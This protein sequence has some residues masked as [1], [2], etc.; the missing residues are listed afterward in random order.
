MK[1]IG[2]LTFEKF[3]KRDK[4]SIGGSRIRMNNLTKYWNEAELFNYGK[5]YDV[6]IYQKVYWHEH[7][8]EFKGIK[9]LDLCD[10]DWLHWAYRVVQMSEYCDA[11]TT[12]TEAL[13]MDFARFTNKPV[14]V[15]PD[16][17]DLNAY[18]FK[19]EH[20]GRAT[21]IGWFGYSQNYHLINESGILKAMLDLN[22]KGENLELVVISNA[23]YMPPAFV[24]GKIEITNLKWTLNNV[25]E[26]IR[27]CD[28]IINPKINKA[29]WQYKSNNKTLHSW[30]LG[31]PVATNYDELI[32][33]LDAD[34]RKEEIKKREFE[35]KDKWDLNLSVK[36]YQDLISVIKNNK[37][38]DK[39]KTL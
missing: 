30:A 4:D 18:P 35:L 32:K 8:K 6:V 13:A 34:N 33:F 1:N 23:I 14:W 25:D 7:A 39:I 31:V 27:S 28:I 11:I 26:D 5:E 22:A 29:N 2:L 24:K 21:K 9:I 37:L 15:I 38:K 10:P 16:R 17:M 12:S 36:E 3:E 19:K 20:Y